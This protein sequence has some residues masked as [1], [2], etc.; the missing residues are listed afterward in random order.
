MIR[1]CPQRRTTSLSLKEEQLFDSVEEMLQYVYSRCVAFSA[2]V[3]SQPP[4]PED[5]A[6]VP[7]SGFPHFYRDECMVTLRRD[8]CVGYCGQC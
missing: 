4:A 1:Y 2:Y 7:F 5:L 6:V 3:G 8:F